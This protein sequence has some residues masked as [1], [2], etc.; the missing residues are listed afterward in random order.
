MIPKD[1][2]LKIRNVKYED[3]F[4][5]VSEKSQYTLKI[6]IITQ[7]NNPWDADK[8]RKGKQL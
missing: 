3:I 6:S 5:L 8:L 4:N 2:F 1:L 7:G